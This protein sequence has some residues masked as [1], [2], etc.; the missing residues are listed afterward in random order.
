MGS[1]F[2]KSF[3]KPV[4]ADVETFVR[5]GQRFARWQD[6]K[7][8]T[9][10]APLTTGKDG[11][12]R[13][14]IES[15][16]YIAKWRDGDGIVREQ[17]TGCRD[18]T[19]ARGVLADL[20]RRAELVKAKVITSAEDR[21]ADHQATPLTDHI[22]AY[23]AHLDASGV[24][25]KHRYETERR[26]QRVVQD[27]GSAWPTWTGRRWS[28]GWCSAWPSG[29]RPAPGIPISARCWLSATGAL[30]PTG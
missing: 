13:L 21:V 30:R 5:K 7:G 11:S 15:P 28:A 10:T 23:L 24:S 17:S 2:K 27:C 26:L 6:S 20:E 22:S 12:Q 16:V 3:T 29:C 9:R 1:V 19:A 4:P 18:E 14:L 8:R 25:G